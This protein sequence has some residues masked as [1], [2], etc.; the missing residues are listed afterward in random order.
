VPSISITA[1]SN[2]SSFNTTRVNVSGT[3]TETALKQITVNGVLAFVNGNN[4]DALNV[5][6]AP[7]GNT[8]TAI[9]EDLAGNTAQ[10]P[11]V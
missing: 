4:F 9:A 1:P 2:N 10:T 7:G 11:L 3:I 8:I 6:L 5:P